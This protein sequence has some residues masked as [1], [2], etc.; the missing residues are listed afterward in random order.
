[1]FLRT[2]HDDARPVKRPADFWH[3]ERE[4]YSRK[5]KEWMAQRDVSLLLQNKVGDEIFTS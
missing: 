1:M 3:I 4:K 2:Y 5:N